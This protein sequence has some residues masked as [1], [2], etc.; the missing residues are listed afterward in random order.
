MDFRFGADVEDGN[1]VHLGT[2]SRAVYDPATGEIV[3]IA[4]RR[5]EVVDR[6]VLVPIGTVQSSEGDI[7]YLELNDDQVDALDDFVVSRNVAPPP[8]PWSPEAVEHAEASDMPSVSPMGAAAGIESIAFTPIVEEGL[9]VPSGDQVL[10]ETTAVWASD[11]D[12]GRIGVVVGDDET[13]RLKSIVV[14]GSLSADVEV[15]VSAIASIQTGTVVLKFSRAD[16]E[17]LIAD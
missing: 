17:A 4:C 1:G 16:V 15:P 11:A 7:L 6:E 3:A 12:I 8:D 2:L 13:R 10:D 5:T 9:D 14:T